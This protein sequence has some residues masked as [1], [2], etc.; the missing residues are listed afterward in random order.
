MPQLRIS[1][2]LAIARPHNPVKCDPFCCQVDQAPL[3]VTNTV[4]VVSTGQVST[5]ELFC[6]SI[7]ISLAIS[8]VSAFALLCSRFAICL[9][10]LPLLLPP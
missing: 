9:L 4:Q 7:W 1:R 8:L 2:G 10:L 3:G 6:L 5:A